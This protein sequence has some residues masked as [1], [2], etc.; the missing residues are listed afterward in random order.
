MQFAEPDVAPPRVPTT[1]SAAVSKRKAGSAVAHFPGGGVLLTLSSTDDDSS[2]DSDLEILAFVPRAKPRLPLPPSSASPAASATSGAKRP[3]EMIV[4]AASSSAALHGHIPKKRRKKKT[5]IGNKQPTEAA[6]S[7]PPVD[8]G[9]DVD[10]KHALYRI[11]HDKGAAAPANLTPFDPLLHVPQ[12]E[13]ESLTSDWSGVRHVVLLDLDNWLGYFK[14][15]PYAF[16][17]DVYLWVF[18]GKKTVPRIPRASAPFLHLRALHHIQFTPC[19]ERPDAA[20]FALCF[21]VG[22]LHQLCDKSIHFTLYSGDRGFDELLRHI[23][24]RRVQRVDLH[25]AGDG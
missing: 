3:F 14:S 4:A 18:Y 10:Y 6:A 5:T 20:D 24:G 19:G 9:S 23:H 16:L 25:Q 1:A 13:L 22:E 17:N 2:D 11:K 15:M 8:S 21:K 7:S 12:E